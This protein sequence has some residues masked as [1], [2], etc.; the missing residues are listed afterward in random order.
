MACVMKGKSNMEIL[1]VSYPVHIYWHTATA[2]KDEQI[3]HFIMVYLQ[4]NTE[5]YLLRWTE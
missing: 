1:T 4:I 3:M 2:L 5:S